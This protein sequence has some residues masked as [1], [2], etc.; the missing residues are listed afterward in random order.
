MTVGEL[1]KKLAKCDGRKKMYWEDWSIYKISLR[2]II[3]I[4]EH[5]D[6]ISIKIDLTKKIN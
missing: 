1:R 2:P 5:D 3:D 6:G 4:E